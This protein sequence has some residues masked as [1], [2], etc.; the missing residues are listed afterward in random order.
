MVHG[1]SN[2]DSLDIEIS[3]TLFR[4][5]ATNLEDLIHWNDNWLDPCWNII[6]LVRGDSFRRMTSLWMYGI[7]YSTLGDI[8]RSWTYVDDWF[9]G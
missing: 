7:S 6:P 3:P 5:I 9:Q 2:S 8:Q 4:V 1:Y